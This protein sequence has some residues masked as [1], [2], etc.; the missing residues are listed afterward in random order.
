MEL[1]GVE[2]KGKETN[3]V[4]ILQVNDSHVDAAMVLEVGVRLIVRAGILHVEG[5]G[6][7]GL[8]EDR[9]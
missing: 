5:I 4:G 2:R 8:G 1:N 7:L 3:D 9:A 6:V